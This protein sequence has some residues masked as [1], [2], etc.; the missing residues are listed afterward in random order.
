MN[1]SFISERSLRISYGNIFSHKSYQQLLYIRQ[2]L[3][4]LDAITEA[5]IGYTT[6]T[7][8]FDPFH[9]THE[10]L[11]SIISELIKEDKTVQLAGEHIKIPVCYEGEYA[12]DIEEVA[13]Y[14]R[15]TIED[16]IEYHCRKSYEVLF[17]GFA[18]GFPFLS[19]I[20]ARLATPRRINPR[21][22][23]VR[24]SVG[25][26]GKQTGIYPSDSPGGWQIIG[27]TPI[28]L[29]PMHKDQATLLKAGDSIEFYPISQQ[30]Y[31]ELEKLDMTSSIQ[32]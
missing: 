9:F 29:L 14:H 1:I 23:V 8:Y 27:R 2:H 30:E 17:L 16:V 6:L 7:V 11:E 10:E 3:L 21:R 25:I 12:P 5:V 26:A 19:E 4:S 20:D 18:P 15:M 32:E 31:V 28:N 13:N 24:G 22:N